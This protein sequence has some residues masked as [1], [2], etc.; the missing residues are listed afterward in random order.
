MKSTRELQDLAALGQDIQAAVDHLNM[1]LQRADQEG[2]EVVA[3]AHN[4]SGS[5][6]NRPT[7]VLVAVKLHLG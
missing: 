6:L 4:K 3:T 5:V 7:H 2:L 1:L